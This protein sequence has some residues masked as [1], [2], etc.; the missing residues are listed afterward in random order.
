MQLCPNEQTY[1]IWIEAQ[2]KELVDKYKAETRKTETE[3]KLAT[4]PNAVAKQKA[5]PVS[6][7]ENKDDEN[8]KQASTSSKKGN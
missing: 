2:V 8:K 3:K 6:V 7:K 4:S 1:R 5:V